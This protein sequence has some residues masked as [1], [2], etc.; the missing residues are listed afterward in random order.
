M[1]YHKTI[2][3]LTNMLETLI[4]PQINQRLKYVHFHYS[5]KALEDPGRKCT[6]MIDV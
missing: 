5:S 4:L 1:T 3:T 6:G 2:S